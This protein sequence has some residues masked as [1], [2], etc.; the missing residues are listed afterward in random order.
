MQIYFLH[1]SA[2]CVKMDKSLLVFDY[3]QDR[4]GLHMGG[5]GMDELTGVSRVYVFAS[6]AHTDHFNACIF[7]W[8]AYNANITY[9]LDATIAA[10]TELPEGAVILSRGESFEDGYIRVREFGST[11]IGGSFY[12]E[13]EGKRL[14]HAG[15]LNNW[16]WKDEGNARYARVM[17]MYFERELRF[18]RH[19]VAHIDYAFFPVDARMG[20]DFDAGADTFIE[21]M[22]PDVL[23]PI[24][25]VRFAD[26]L[27]YSRKQAGGPTR[28]LSISRKGERLV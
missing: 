16:H 4:A 14:F 26:T 1:H 19:E 5:I 21:T 10:E 20:S 25:F 13:C 28:V 15:D 7:D 2:V 6:H 9:V 23:I 17:G 24:H 12:V 11:D 18:I 27:A 22:R 8:A 3:Y